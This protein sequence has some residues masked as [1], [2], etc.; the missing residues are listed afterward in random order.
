[1]CNGVLDNVVLF[2]PFVMSSFPPHLILLYLT[3]QLSIQ[4]INSTLKGESY[5]LIS[6]MP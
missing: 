3:I 2:N 4:T 1:M 5:K 6:A